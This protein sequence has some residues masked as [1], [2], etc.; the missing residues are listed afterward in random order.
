MLS[1]LS[2]SCQAGRLQWQYP[3]PVIALM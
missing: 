3:Y 1:M 2:G